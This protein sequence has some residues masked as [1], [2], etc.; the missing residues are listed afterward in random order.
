MLAPGNRV[1]ME[2]DGAHQEG[3]VWLLSSI[4]WTMRDAAGYML[5]F[6]LK[7]PL[8]AILCLMTPRLALRVRVRTGNVLLPW[9]LVYLV[10]CAMII[11]HMYSFSN[12]LH[13]IYISISYA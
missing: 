13:A 4:L 6:S 9:I 3:L 1:R 5:R 10:L 7:T 11:P 12:N 2:T 8:L